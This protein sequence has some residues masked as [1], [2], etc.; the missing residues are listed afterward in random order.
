MEGKEGKMGGR[1]TRRV[2]HKNL[3]TANVTRVEG[4]ERKKLH[5]Q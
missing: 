3:M 5:P 2:E 1:S 4:K